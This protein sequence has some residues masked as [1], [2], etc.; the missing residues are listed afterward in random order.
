MTIN[1]RKTTVGAPPQHKDSKKYR[2]RPADEGKHGDAAEEP[3]SGVPTSSPDTRGRPK[4]SSS[5]QQTGSGQV[6]QT[7]S[8]EIDVGHS[9][10]P[11]GKKRG[12]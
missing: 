3:N 7:G 1:Q 5:R 11:G 4:S 6:T 2:D 12:V 9:R 8:P 10:S